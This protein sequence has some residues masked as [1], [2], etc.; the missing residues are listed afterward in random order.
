MRTI[1]RTA[2]LAMALLWPQ[3]GP[4]ESAD[5]QASL[6]AQG[7]QALAAGDL[8]TAGRHYAEARELKPDSAFAWLG[9][10]GVREGQGKLTEALTLA[11]RAEE[12]A[13]DEPAASMALARVLTRLGAVQPALDALAKARRLDPEDPPSYLLAALLLRDAG[14]GDEAIEL[15]EAARARGLEAPEVSEELGLLLLAADRADDAREVAELALE[16]HPR[17]A[18]LVLVQGLALAAGGPE[19]KSAAIGRLEESLELGVSQPGRVRLELGAL[20]AGEGR[21]DEALVH[22]R[23][24]RRLLPDSA[25]VQYRLGAALRAAADR[26]GARAALERFREISRQ[27]EAEDWS[28][29]EVGTALN[30]A[31]A[32]AS[33]N[34]LAAALEHLDRL[35]ADHPGKARAW[36]LKAKVLFSMGR[37]REAVASIV[38]AR[39]LTPGKTEPHYLEGLFLMRLGRPGDAEAALGRALALDATLGEAWELLGGIAAKQ[40][41]PAEAAE[42]FRRALAAGADGPGLR[43]GYAGALEELGRRPESEEQMAAYRRLAGRSE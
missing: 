15:L 29:K 33:D 31:Q 36:T 5:P 42:R 1:R 13:P 21:S 22:L 26:E 27:E 24:A 4:A 9:L 10:A 12:L 41:R 16:R 8:E 14:R 32:L 30:E 39:E 25:E 11:R 19:L 17:R 7:A 43:L 20:L 34:R 18:E 28:A 2:C 40:D 3:T 38:R 6:I 23:E 35:L 37:G